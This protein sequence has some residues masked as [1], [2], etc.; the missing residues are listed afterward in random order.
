MRDPWLP[1]LMILIVVVGVWLGISG[2][3]P[4]GVTSWLHYWQ[5]LIGVGVALIAA[6]IAFSNTTR[7][8]K[9]GQWLED[10]RRSRK[11]AAVRAVLPLALAQVSSYAENSARALNALIDNCVDEALPRKSIPIDFVER[12]PSETLAVLAEL[13]EYSDNMDA[14]VIETT[15]AWIQIHDSRLRGLLH[16]N[17]DPLEEHTVV[18][19]EIEG[20]IVDAASIYAGAGAVYGYARRQQTALPTTITWDDVRSA[21]RNMRFWD[22]QYPRLGANVGRREA[23]WPTPIDQLT[24]R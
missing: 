17:Y 13:I 5:T 15:V 24:R 10:R 16:D 1:I 19:N 7:S 22:G 21:L 14:S 8:L 11:Q 4:N 20:L 6:C 3:L 18:R 23:R 12:L 2:P 9:H